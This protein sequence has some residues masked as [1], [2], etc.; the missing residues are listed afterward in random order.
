M[1]R[2]GAG[3][4]MLR[5]VVMKKIF[6]AAL[7]ATLAGSLHAAEPGA[8]TATITFNG[9]ITQAACEISS[10]DQ[11][12]T[13]DLGVYD[14]KLFTGTEYHTPWKN[15]TVNVTGC[16]FSRADD[17]TGYDSPTEVPANLVHIKFTDTQY[18]DAEHGDG[19]LQGSPSNAGG[20]TYATGVGIEVQYK[21]GTG[22]EDTAYTKLDFAQNEVEVTADK[23]AYQ[24]IEGSGTT[25][26]TLSF[27]AG[28][29]QAA[30]GTPV[31]AGKVT[32]VMTMEV[33][34]P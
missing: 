34:Y 7:A 13:V 11:T 17:S 2:K 1:K 22:S 16:S 24:P 30:S 14:A 10:S 9:Y 29:R 33:A 27:R 3:R 8:S 32:G 15:F 4:S 20:D 19:L 26:Q 21:S 5:E 12:K 31:T 18:R 23:F 28:M 6:A 25:G